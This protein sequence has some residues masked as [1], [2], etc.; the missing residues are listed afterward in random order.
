[1]ERVRTLIVDDEKPARARLLEL[2]QREPEIAVVGEGRDGREAIE[3][4]R[5][6]TP[7]LMFLDIQMPSVDGF[8]VLRAIEPAQRPVTIFV[9]AYDRYAIQAFEAHAIDY[10]LK[11]YSD[12]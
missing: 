12:Q 10:L 8:G 3:L 2:L 9:T 7:N 11:P 6:C 4:V 1:M 5:A